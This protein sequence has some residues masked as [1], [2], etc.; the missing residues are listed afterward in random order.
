MAKIQM[1][2]DP[3]CPWAW[4]TSRWLGDVARQRDLDV[5]WN[6]MSLGVLNEGKEDPE[7][8]A[9]RWGPARVVNAARELYGPEVVKGL[10]DALGEAIHHEGKP[11]D[12][13]IPAALAASGL[14]GNLE[15]Y[16]DSDELDESLRSSHEAGMSLVGEDVGTPIIAVDEVAFFGPVISPA[17]TGEEALALF[18][19]VVAVAAYDGFFE[20][21]RTR[22]RDPIF[23]VS[24]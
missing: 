10:Y 11:Y 23:E 15:R 8:N 19:G 9:K 14:P 18:D 5:S 7:K 4:M 21:K 6:I 12:E 20:L 1:W 2:F 16:A 3:I 17:P 22:T 24:S 13:A